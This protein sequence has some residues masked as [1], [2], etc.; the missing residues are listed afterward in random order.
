MSTST[1]TAAVDVIVPFRDQAPWL[2]QTGLSL[3]RQICPHWRALLIN[4]GSGPEALAAAAHLCQSDQRFQLLHRRGPKPAPGPWQ[5]RNLGISAASAPLV[6]F[7]DADDLWHPEKL[8]QQ[9]TLHQHQ[10]NVLSV[11]SYHRFQSTSLA[12]VETRNPP[13]RLDQAELLR[14]NVIPLSAVIIDRTLLLDSGGF[15]PEHHEDYGLWLRLFAAAAPPRYLCL[16]EPLM[17]YRL[18]PQS[19]SAA[20][21]RSLLA[22]NQLFH[23]H[24]PQR[25]Q[26][27]PALLRWGL[28]R[29]CQSLPRWRTG[30]NRHTSPALLPEPF[31]S[32]LSPQREGESVES[33]PH[34]S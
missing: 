10:P 7:L 9:L 21:H 3:Q 14:G 11:C 6:A 31:L 32:L 17:A 2:E 24:L 13:S 4:D 19:L 25:R 34:T 20:R 22:V 5:A 28:E 16:P 29:G 12:L 1:Q 18:H 23:Q 8:A 15:R 30:G 27:W 33:P 26:R